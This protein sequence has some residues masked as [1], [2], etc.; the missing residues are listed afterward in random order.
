MIDLLIT[1]VFALISAL[2]GI[3]IKDIKALGL[4]TMLTA[5][6][7]FLSSYLLNMPTVLLGLVGLATAVVKISIHGKK[8]VERTVRTYRSRR[9]LVKLE[10]SVKTMPDMIIDVIPA[11]SRRAVHPKI[12]QVFQVVNEAYNRGY[13]VEEPEWLRIIRIY[14]ASVGSEVRPSRTKIISEYEVVEL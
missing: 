8:V 1:A 9:R 10:E 2:G 7:T 11:G 3:F 5:V 6:A 14:Q 12:L 13:V 4:F